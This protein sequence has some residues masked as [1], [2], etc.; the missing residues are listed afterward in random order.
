[1]GLSYS[2]L[3]IFGT[4]ALVDFGSAHFVMWGIFGLMNKSL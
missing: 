4:K 1:V 3:I 2:A